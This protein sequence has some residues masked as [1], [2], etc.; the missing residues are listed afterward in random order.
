[1]TDKKTKLSPSTEDYLEAIYLLE[2]KQKGVRLTDVAQ[3]LSVSKPSVN[4]A[5]EL[6]MQSSLVEKEKYSLIYLTP[7]GNKKAQEIIFRHQT[8]KEFLTTILEVSEKIAENEAC[9]IE[10]AM[11][12][13]TVLK[14]DLFLKKY[15]KTSD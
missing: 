11:S 5:L 12:N 10:H 9:M 4:K 2:K 7:K 3:M 8:I 13:Q 1:M 15:K 14:M 6:M